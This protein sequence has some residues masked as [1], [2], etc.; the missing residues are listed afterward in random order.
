VES[1]VRSQIV[2][3]IADFQFDQTW[4]ALPITSLQPFERP[5]SISERRIIPRERERTDI[6]LP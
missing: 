2:P 4:R 5:I 6:V 1:L 3:Y